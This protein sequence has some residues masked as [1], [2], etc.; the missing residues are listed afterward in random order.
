MR[1]CAIS[2]RY[3]SDLQRQS[4]NEDQIRG[5][6]EYA[7][8]KAWLI[9]EDYVVADSEVSGEAMAGRD[10][11]HRLLEAARTNPLPF[12]C[13]LLE[14]TSRLARNLPDQLRMIDRFAFHGVSVVFFSQ[15]IDTS[16]QNARTLA[17]LHGMVDEQFLVGLRDKVHRGQHG[18][19]LQGMIPGGRCYGYRN[20]PIED[21]NRTGKY[22]RPAIL[23]VSPEINGEEAEVVRRMFKMYADGMGVG[24]SAKQL[25]REGVPAPV[26]AKNRLHRAWSRY[27]VWEML[28]N[29][30]YRGVLVWNRTKKVRNP[31]TG[32]KISKSRPESERVRVEVPELR[33]VPEDLWQAVHDRIAHVKDALGIARVGGLSRTRRTYLF[34]GMLACGECNSS[35]VIVSGMGKRGYVKYGCHAHKHT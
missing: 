30:R 22:G 24:Q 26:P 29:E 25:N 12:D 17:T 7:R 14:D 23:G 4:S 19:V 28:R 5:A 13:V 18:R 20:V 15:G 21:P 16:Q 33:I 8:Q 1:R 9:V 34:S 31:E 32:R 3:S 6:R 11:L 27:T 10:G 2:A 35:M